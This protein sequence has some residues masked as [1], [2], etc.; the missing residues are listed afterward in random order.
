MMAGLCA[1]IGLLAGC[2]DERVCGAGDAPAA[3][4]TATIGNASI[5]YG[6]FTASA[7]NDCPAS[8]GDRTSITI[9]GVQTDPTPGMPY[10]MT[11]CLPRPGQ[12]GGA[13]VALDDAA[14]VELIDVWAELPDGCRVQLDHATPP[15]GTIELL[16]YCYDQGSQSYEDGYAMKLDATITGE[17]ICDGLPREPVT[18]ALSGTVAVQA[19]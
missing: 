5:T 13:P 2:A 17:R 1:G 12:L 14:L 7:N 15:T 16:G 4:V 9:D 10:H 19:E 18:L 3:G 6:N 11:L 8:D